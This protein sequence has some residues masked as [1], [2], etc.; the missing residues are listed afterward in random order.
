[1]SV[2]GPD[3]LI[4]S[5]TY[6]D[7]R[8]G[9]RRTGEA[10]V[11]LPRNPASRVTTMRKVILFVVAVAASTAFA[12][13]TQAQSTKTGSCADVQWNDA[14]KKYPDIT[15][16]CIAVVERNGKKYIK[17]SGKVTKKTKDTLTILLDHS[18]ADMIWA[19][20]LGEMVSIDGKDIPAMDVA[21][22]QELRFYVPEAQVTKM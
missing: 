4:I 22:N 13:F 6:A 8:F 18:K 3:G 5:G 1:M 11:N 7:P 17:L 12:Q 14:L 16:S 19:P 21:V 2:Y 15:K 9:Y 20:D 10:G